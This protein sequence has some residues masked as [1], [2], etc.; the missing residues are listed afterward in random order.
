VSYNPQAFYF[1]S[2]HNVVSCSH[3]P[4]I[5]YVNSIVHFVIY[6]RPA[7]T[8][9]GC[10]LVEIYCPDTETNEQLTERSTWTAEWSIKTTTTTS[11]LRA[12][13]SHFTER[14]TSITSHTVINTSPLVA[15]HDRSTHKQNEITL[16]ENQYLSVCLGSSYILTYSLCL[17]PNVHAR[18]LYG[19]FRYYIPVNFRLK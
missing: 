18:C 6:F 10:I 19:K 8:S 1:L 17:S 2:R 5:L 16:I 12:T 3:F 14:R 7:L 9:L 11:K 15:V 13:T 4:M